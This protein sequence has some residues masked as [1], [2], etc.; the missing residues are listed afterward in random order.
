MTR[1]PSA[2]TLDDR[3]GGT[4]NGNDTVTQEDAARGPL[5]GIRVLE[6][7]GIGPGP[8]CAMLLADLGAEVVRID[9]PGGSQ[10]PNRVVDRG[11]YVMEVDIRTEEGRELCQLAADKADVLIEGFRPGVMER[12]GLGPDV[13]LQRNPRL[14]YGRMTG[15]GQTG[16]LAQV[17]G[18]DINYIALSGALAA[19]GT[20]G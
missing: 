12:L 18:H 5:A 17:A 15:W 2:H 10:W 6:F 13:L 20:P 9:R 16:S 19:I 4:V 1:E 14:V 8:Y 11:R 7:A 3:S